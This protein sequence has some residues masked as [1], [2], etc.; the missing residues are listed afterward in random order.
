M[1]ERIEKKLGCT[2]EEYLTKREE[3][4]SEFDT[5][6]DCEVNPLAEMLTYEELDYLTEYVLKQNLDNAS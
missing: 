6:A 5:E 4:F 1:K 3:M 2:I